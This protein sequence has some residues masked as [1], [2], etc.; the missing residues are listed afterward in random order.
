MPPNKMNLEESMENKFEQ[1]WR[2][3][4]VLRNWFISF[5]IG[6]V[7]IFITHPDIFIYLSNQYKRDV[8][9]LFLGG[10]LLQVLLAGINKFTHWYVYFG[11][12]KNLYNKSLNITNKIEI[13]L[14]FDS[15][16]FFFFFSAVSILLLFNH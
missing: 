6:G 5:G 2:H 7:I 14:F 1:Y 3:A 15:I 10:V 9:L 13:D 8:I 11:E 4:S 12:P 16:T